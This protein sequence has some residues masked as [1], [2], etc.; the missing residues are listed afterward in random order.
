MAAY[1]VLF[2]EARPVKDAS[3]SKAS[4]EKYAAKHVWRTAEYK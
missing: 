4:H 2:G 1:V 3:S